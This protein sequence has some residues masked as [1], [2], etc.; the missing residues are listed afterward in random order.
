MDRDLIVRV[1]LVEFVD[2]AHAVVREHQRPG[3]DAKVARVLI[4]RDGGGQAGGAR[5]LAR[6]VDAPV[7]QEGVN[8]LEKLRLR[9]RRIPDDAYVDVPAQ[10]NALGCSFVYAGEEHEEDAAFDFLVAEGR[11]RDGVC[12][13]WRE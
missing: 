11:G 8:E 7:G 13:L 9:R 2:A 12:Q 3:L 6:R 4:A 5:R 10:A 1:H